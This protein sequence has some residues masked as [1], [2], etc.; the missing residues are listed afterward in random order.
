MSAAPISLSNPAG[1]SAASAESVSENSSE[2]AAHI[3]MCTY[4]HPN[5]SNGVDVRAETGR[6]RGSRTP[7]PWRH[8]GEDSNGDAVDVGADHGDNTHAATPTSPVKSP[9]AMSAVGQVRVG[10]FAEAEEKAES[11]ATTRTRQL[12]LRTFIRHRVDVA[13][14]LVPTNISA[15]PTRV[16]VILSL[17]RDMV[18]SSFL[19]IS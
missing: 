6:G 15:T 13:A 18:S 5:V 2:A 14:E 19:C 9:C 3:T 17:F 10:A 12:C 8:V 1:W 4:N 7:T 11:K 16:A